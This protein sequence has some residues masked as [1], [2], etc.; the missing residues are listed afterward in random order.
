VVG[1]GVDAA[2]EELEDAGFEVRLQDS[3]IYIGVGFVVGQD[4]EGGTMAPIG[5][6]ITLT[7]V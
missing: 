5:S 3:D 6:T 4:P 7:R 2:V 1:A